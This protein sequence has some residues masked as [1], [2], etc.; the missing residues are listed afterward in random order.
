[1]EFPQNGKK[2]IWHEVWS[3]ITAVSFRQTGEMGELGGP[4][5]RAVTIRGNKRGDAH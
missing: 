1:M 5:K 4:L 3:G 2:M